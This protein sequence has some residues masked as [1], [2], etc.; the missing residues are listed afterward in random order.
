MNFDENFYSDLE[1][2]QYEENKELDRVEQLDNY[3]YP[4]EPHHESIQAPF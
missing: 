1:R 2:E 4:A 3:F